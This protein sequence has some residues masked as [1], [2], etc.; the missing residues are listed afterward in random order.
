MFGVE[1]FL[2]E[3]QLHSKDSTKCMDSATL[4]GGTAGDPA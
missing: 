4:I 3:T 1:G 2:R